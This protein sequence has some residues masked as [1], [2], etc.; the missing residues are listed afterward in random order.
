[1]PG[2]GEL[3][4]FG[5]KS[6]SFPPYPLSYLP[7]PSTLPLFFPFFL[8]TKHWENNKVSRTLW[9]K[10]QVHLRSFNQL[11]TKIFICFFFLSFFFIFFVLFLQYSS[12]SS[13]IIHFR[14]IFITVH[15][16]KPAF[17][18]LTNVIPCLTCTKPGK[19]WVTGYKFLTEP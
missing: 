14:Y 16:F 9:A 19:R 5:P 8:F 1:M 6:V 10:T 11:D 4:L 7:L 13:L 18:Y 15:H 2:G 17:L 12:F 3:N